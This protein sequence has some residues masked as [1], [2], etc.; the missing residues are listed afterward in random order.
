MKQEEEEEG[1]EI[2]SRYEFLL[3]SL[4]LF[5]SFKSL[6]FSMCVSLANQVSLFFFFTAA[7]REQVTLKNTEKKEKKKRKWVYK[8]INSCLPNREHVLA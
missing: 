8:R 7:D 1:E 4:G 6:V 2:K 5:H 3:L